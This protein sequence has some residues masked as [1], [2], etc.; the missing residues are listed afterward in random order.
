MCV[1]VAN[2][3]MTSLRFEIN[4]RYIQR[5]KKNKRA[6]YIGLNLNT[7]VWSLKLNWYIS[8][9]RHKEGIQNMEY[10]YPKNDIIVNLLI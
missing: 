2:N 1:S 8:Y 3:Q 5:W 6:T 7:N 9:F 4:S 10:N